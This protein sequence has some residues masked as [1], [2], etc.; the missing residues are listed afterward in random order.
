MVT[1]YSKVFIHLKYIEFIIIK[2][3]FFCDD[4]HTA[5]T[6]HTAHTKKKVHLTLSTA[7]TKLLQSFPKELESH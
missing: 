3:S 6:A 7:L 2:Y 1:K 5:H 4:K